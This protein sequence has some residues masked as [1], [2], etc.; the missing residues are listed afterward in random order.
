MDNDFKI[1]E[2]NGSDLEGMLPVFN[3]FA[4]HGDAVYT[5]MPLSLNRFKKLIEQVKIG[6]VLENGDKIIGFGYISAY[7]P[8]PNFDFTGVL[9]YFI[10]PQYTGIGLGTRLF[11]ELIKRGR[12]A[13]INNFLA[14]ISSM[15]EQSLNFHKKKGFVTV[16]EFKNVAVKNSR[17]FDIIWV[18]KQYK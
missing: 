18:Q 16:G 6:L 4:E 8:Y 5:D 17:L 15:N 11:D 2:Y 13:G 1:R 9:T 7:K 10:M 14:H 12:Q 3:Y